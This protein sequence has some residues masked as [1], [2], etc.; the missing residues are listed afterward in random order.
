MPAAATPASAGRQPAAS[1]QRQALPQRL[2]LQARH[3]WPACKGRQALRAGHWWPACKGR[4]CN[5]RG[6][7]G[8]ATGGQPAK[9]G[10][11]ATPA[12]AGCQPVAS[13]QRQASFAG[14]AATPAFAGLPPVASLQGQV[15]FAGLPPM[16]SLQM[17]TLLGYPACETGAATTPSLRSRHC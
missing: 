17:R 7:C 6:L 11:A 8:L 13:L 3:Q 16:S 9:A 5:N 10:G 14:V 4:C 12:F 2:P 15:S 1:L